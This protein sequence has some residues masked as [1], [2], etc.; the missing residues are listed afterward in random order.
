M[1]ACTCT[2][3]PR[4]AGECLCRA[5]ADSV[6]AL[7]AARRAWRNPTAAQLW[8]NRHNTRLGGVPLDLILAG[9]GDQ[10][11]AESQCAAAEASR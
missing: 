7:R 9:R 11:V 4:I 5:T 2:D 3:A 10:V 8:L 1:T 6:L